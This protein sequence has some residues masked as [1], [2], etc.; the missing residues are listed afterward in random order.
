M[1]SREELET[2]G[3]SQ[4]MAERFAKGVPRG[5]YSNNSFE[6]A[7]GATLKDIRDVV[8]DKSYAAPGAIYVNPDAREG[9]A[10]NIGAREYMLVGRNGPKF[11]SDQ[12][13]AIIEF[14]KTGDI[15]LG[16]NDPTAR[17][18]LKKDW[19]QFAEL[20][21]KRREAMR[22]LI[23]EGYTYGEAENM[24]LPGETLTKDPKVVDENKRA[25]IKIDEDED[26]EYDG[27][28]ESLARMA[29]VPMHGPLNF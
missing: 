4:L 7:G 15:K 1:E 14:L 10:N 17:A 22:N 13:D 28:D 20:F 29:D 23:G 16:D 6:K 18:Q 25:G 19:D 9:G 26:D 27:S 12:W 3:I 5:A 11:Y 21:D 2:K 24:T 8:G